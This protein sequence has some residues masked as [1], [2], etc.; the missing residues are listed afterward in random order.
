[1][2]RRTCQGAQ[3]QAKSSPFITRFDPR[4]AAPSAD[5]QYVCRQAVC[6]RED[7]RLVS[8]GSDD[9]INERQETMAADG[10]RN[11]GQVIDRHVPQRA[12]SSGN[13]GQ[14]TAAPCPIPLYMWQ[15]AATAHLSTLVVRALDGPQCAGALVR[16]AQMLRGRGGRCRTRTPR[17]PGQVGRGADR[18]EDP[19]VRDVHRAEERPR[20]YVRRAVLV[21]LLRTRHLG[22][23]GRVRDLRRVRMGG[24][25]PGRP[26]RPSCAWRPKRSPEPC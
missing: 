9:Q 19:L 2:R 18:P 24:R 17:R 11:E 14:S 4:G 23:A 3:E 8:H 1:M 7:R 10:T 16:S 20:G 22:R 25:R 13:Q 21:S 26:R 15:N 5:Q 12:G 6:V